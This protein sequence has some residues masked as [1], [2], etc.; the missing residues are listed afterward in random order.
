MCLTKHERIFRTA[1]EAKEGNEKIIMKIIFKNVFKLQE[2]NERSE[3]ILGYFQPRG[4][5]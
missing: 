3:D 2:I 4:A 5:M 1:R